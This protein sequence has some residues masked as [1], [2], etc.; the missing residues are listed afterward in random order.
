MAGV[1]ADP[2]VYYLLQCVHILEAPRDYVTA[3][4]VWLLSNTVL[5]ADTD[6]AVNQLSN[7]TK[8]GRILAGALHLTAQCNFLMTHH[9]GLLF[10]LLRGSLPAATVLQY[11]G[12]T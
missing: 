4:W 5:L 8:A 1:D 2:Q 12:E 3:L 9:E 10:V 6:E 7:D 11:T